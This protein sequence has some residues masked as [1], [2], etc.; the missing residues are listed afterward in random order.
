MQWMGLNEVR[1]KFLS[2]FEGKEHYRLNSFPLVP[3][4]DKSLLLINSGMA[5]MKK[6][7]TGEETPPSKRVTTCQKCIRTPDIE[8]VG[9]TSRHGT[10]FEMLGNFSFGD[11]FK[12]EVT[13]WAWEFCTKVMELPVDRLYVS[14]YLEDDETYDIWTKKIGVSPD[15]MVRLGKADNFW[16]IGSGPCGPCSEIYFDRGEKYGCGNPDC[17]PGCDCDRFVEFWN[18]VFSQFENDGNGNYS[19]LKQKNIDTGM[20]LERLACIVQGVDNLF[21]VDTV[22]NIIKH[23]SKIANVNYHDDD[24]K[25]ISIRVITDHIRGSVFMICDGVLTSNEGRGYVLRRL[26]RRAARHGKLLGIKGPFLYKVVETVINENKGAYPELL[27]KKALIEKVVKIEEENFA[28]TIDQGLS[29]LDSFISDLEKEGKKTLSGADAFKLYDTFGFPVDMTSDILEEKGFELDLDGFNALMNEQKVR[30]RNAR[31]ELGDLGWVD[32]GEIDLSD[33]SDTVFTGYDSLNEKSEIIAIINDGKLFTEISDNEKAV[34]I[35]NKTPFYAESGGQVGDTGEISCENGKFI[36]SDTKK[37]KDGKFMHIGYLE[38][39]MLSV[40]DTVE[41]AVKSE[42]RASIMRNHSAAHLLQAALR[43]VLGSHVEQSGSYVDENRV[44]FDFTHFSAMTSDEISKV[45]CL[46]NEMILEDVCVMKKELPIEE[47]K[48]LG[49]MALFGEKYGDIVRVVK[50]SDFSVEFCGGTHVDNTGKLGLFKIISENSV[51]SG[52]RR[53]EGTTG[54]GVLKLLEEANNTILNVASNLKL[55]NINEVVSKTESVMN[56][57]KEKDREIDILNSKLA[58]T[59]IDDLFNSATEFKGIKVITSEFNGASMDVIR[60]LGD[61]IKDK[62]EN[63]I[64][65]LT[66]TAGDKA[67][68]YCVCGKESVKKGANAGTIVREVAK[69]T[70]GGGGGKPDSAMA[71]AKDIS[72]LGEALSKLPEILETLIKE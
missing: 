51:A 4:N 71:G 45:E 11:Y 18:L 59:Q 49:A 27:E 60:N 36:V 33:L 61:L 62:A 12:N 40:N 67:T 30:A 19:D 41:L 6:Y 29:I 17:A 50:M 34:I 66:N 70:G 39:G 58:S 55:K 21:E 24:K 64:A 9:K 42:R 7:F 1:E 72:K 23:I 63:V 65:V 16:E 47:A 8:N 3:I 44:R 32:S 52:V 22:Q 69:V 5:P 31:N 2:F 57:L 14:V 28:K 35:V 68:I 38:D 37:T 56:E 13:G 54:V 10:F 20:G 46:V 15:H 26:L 48:K 25:D 43:K 53:I